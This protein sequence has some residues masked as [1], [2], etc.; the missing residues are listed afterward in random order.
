MNNPK[1][2]LRVVSFIEE[3]GFGHS[4]F[5]P[6]VRPSLRLCRGRFLTVLALGAIRRPASP[7][8]TSSLPQCLCNSLMAFE[9]ECSQGQGMEQ[10]F[11]YEKNRHHL[12]IEAGAGF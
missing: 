6:I 8:S 1:R 2:R 4:H 3:F 9:Y 7:Q 5:S 11:Y 10:L 12:P